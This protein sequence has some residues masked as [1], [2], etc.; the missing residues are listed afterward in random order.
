MK[1]IYKCEKCGEEFESRGECLRHEEKCDSR[2]ALERRIEELERRLKT[3]EDYIAIT[4]PMPSPINVPSAPYTPP[5]P[6]NPCEPS[7]TFPH[8]YPPIWC[9]ASKDAINGMTLTTGGITLEMR[10]DGR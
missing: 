2:D 6:M 5:Y 3:L 4:R 9:D 10:Q 1:K 7:P 8:T